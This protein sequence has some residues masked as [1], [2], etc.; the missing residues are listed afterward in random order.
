LLAKEPKR[1]AR[2]ILGLPLKKVF[3]D[4]DFRNFKLL[5]I[6]R[7][8][9]RELIFSSHTPKLFCLAIIP[10]SYGEGNKLLLSM[11]FQKRLQ[12]KRW[13]GAYLNVAPVIPKLIKGELIK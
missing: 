9:G 1:K 6:S 12:S 2:R 10:I 7:F 4:F 13:K 3:K 11:R 5:G 8:I